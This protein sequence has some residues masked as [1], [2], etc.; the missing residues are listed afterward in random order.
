MTAA[1]LSSRPI[2]SRGLPIGGPAHHSA[3]RAASVSVRVGPCSS[4]CSRQSAVSPS[5]FACHP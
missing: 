1:H 3:I 5:V 4:V 2:A